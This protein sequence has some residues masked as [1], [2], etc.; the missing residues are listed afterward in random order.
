MGNVGKSNF[1]LGVDVKFKFIKL[2]SQQ[3]KVALDRIRTHGTWVGPKLSTN[4]VFFANNLN[5]RHL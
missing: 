5:S 2:Q 4:I 3:K 1:N